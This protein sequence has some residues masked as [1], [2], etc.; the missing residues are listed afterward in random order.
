MTFFRYF[1]PFVLPKIEQIRHCFSLFL[2]IQESKCFYNFSPLSRSSLY[3]ALS[4]FLSPSIHPFRVSMISL[5][6]YEKGQVMQSGMAW[7]DLC[8][9][10]CVCTC[11]CVCVD[12]LNNS[13]QSLFH[14][15]ISSRNN[16]LIRRAQTHVHAHIHTSNIWMNSFS[17]QSEDQIHTHIHTIPLRLSPTLTTTARLLTLTFKRISLLMF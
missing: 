11:A 6:A 3:A 12:Y 9:C 14:P 17:P 2:W 1:T 7:H 10:V 15:L 16:H 4:V 5:C 8:V 13:Q